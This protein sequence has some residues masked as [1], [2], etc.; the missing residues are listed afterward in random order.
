MPITADDLA[1]AANNAGLDSAD[2]LTAFFQG[3]IAQSA[4]AIGQA[5]IKSLITERD[6]ALADFNA[7]IATQQQAI[8][9]AN[10]ALQTTLAGQVQTSPPISAQSA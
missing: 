8:N 3:G 7:Q 4:I 6:A 9:D 2:K 10:T 1:K 5:Q